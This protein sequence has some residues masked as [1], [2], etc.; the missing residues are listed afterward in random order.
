MADWTRPFTAT[1]R[2]MRV[3]RSTGYETAQLDGITGGTLQVNQD[4]ATFES[5]VS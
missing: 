4:T 3:S 2:F 1:Y 5:A